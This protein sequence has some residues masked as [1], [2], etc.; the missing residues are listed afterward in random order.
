MNYPEDLVTAAD[1][2]KKAVPHMVK[3]Q[4]PAN[5]INYTLWYHYVANLTPE[6]NIELD[7]I[8]NTSGSMNNEQSIELFQHFILSQHIEDHQKTLQGFTKLTANLLKHISQSMDGSESFGTELSANI[9]Q[10]K[11]AKS[12]DDITPIVENIINT[13]ENLRNANSDFQNQMKAATEEINELRQNLQQVEKH[14]YIDQLTQI[15]NRH[16]FDRQLQQLLKTDEVAETVCLILFDLDHFKSF[17]D[18]YGHVIGDRVLKKMGELILEN[19]PKEAIGARYGGEEFAIILS[20]SNEEE[21]AEIAEL[22][23]QKIQQLRVKMKN[24]DKVLD[25]ISASFGVTRFQV[26]ENTESF[27]HRADT[28]LYSAK[29]NGRNRVEI[30]NE[31][32]DKTS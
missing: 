8:I 30:Y 9:E 4:I 26:G 7:E 23:R 1:N 5:P 29:G 17:N 21:A 18:D 3:N 15:Y 32:M 24:S 31:E 28:A 14:A 13:S 19:S 25:N 16:A 11:E 27:I 6:L 12:A 20:D 2:L 10:I 22:L